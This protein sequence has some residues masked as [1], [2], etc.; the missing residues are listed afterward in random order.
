[1]N[2]R[3]CLIR[4]LDLYLE[5]RIGTADL[6]SVLEEVEMDYTEKMKLKFKLQDLL[7]EEEMKQFLEDNK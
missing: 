7:A 6:L 5:G 2:E 4:Y 3:D 1:M